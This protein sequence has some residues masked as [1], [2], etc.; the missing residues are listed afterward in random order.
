MSGEEHDA[1]V[2]S[3]GAYPPAAD[4]VIVRTWLITCVGDNVS[5]VGP[6]S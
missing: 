2:G 6:M 1:S 3:H 4:N 5:D